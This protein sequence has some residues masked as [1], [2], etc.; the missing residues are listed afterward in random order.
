MTFRK[1]LPSR[2]LENLLKENGLKP[3]G[4][5]IQDDVF[6]VEFY[7]PR[8][9]TYGLVE[10]RARQVS[11]IDGLEVVYSTLHRGDHPCVELRI[12]LKPEFV[13]SSRH[14]VGLPMTGS[15]PR[16]TGI[17]S[18]EIRQVDSL[19]NTYGRLFENAKAC[20]PDEAFYTLLRD[21]YRLGSLY[22]QNWAQVSYACDLVERALR[23]LENAQ[24]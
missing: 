23:Q 14:L 2:D 15:P 19:W 1:F 20:L 18:K 22:R 11:R 21:L 9:A 10:A 12:R 24:L 7:A 13:A 4:C 17:G 5:R 16:A 6:Q 8:N 3:R